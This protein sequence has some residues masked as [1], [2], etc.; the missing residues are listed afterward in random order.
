MNTSL[1]GISVFTGDTNFP[2]FLNL[3]KDHTAM[4]L[5]T[6]LL[7]SFLGVLV[8]F[9]G[10]SGLMTV[11]L[12]NIER[13]SKV[14]DNV[15]SALF[16]ALIAQGQVLRFILYQDESYA[17]DA[18]KELKTALD[19]YSKAQDFLVFPK[20]K[21]ILQTQKQLITDAEHT[22]NAI[23]DLDKAHLEIDSRLIPLTS[24]LSKR[25]AQL[26]AILARSLA[27]DYSDDTMTSYAKL[28]EIGEL[29][30]DARL[31]A[32]IYTSA[33]SDE[34][35]DKALGSVAQVIKKSKKSKD[36]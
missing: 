29:F 23:C 8:I 21:K 13:Q 20:N 18:F 1:K 9:L 3:A 11:S 7:A 22:F 26:R 15:D 2:Y 12:N 32:R 24:Q 35:K 6:K 17:N 33:P 25:V 28:V 19:L 34:N 31:A 14:V 16:S 4:K 5:R 27:S 36:G 10:V 30:R